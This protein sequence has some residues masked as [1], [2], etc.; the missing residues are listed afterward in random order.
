MSNLRVGLNV[1]IHFH[2]SSSQTTVMSHGRVLSPLT[3]V[4][5]LAEPDSHK[6]V[7][8]FGVMNGVVVEGLTNAV[9]AIEKEGTFDVRV[10]VQ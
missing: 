9:A 7:I 8:V 6:P 3:F 1:D 10:Q 2:K 4:H 5:V